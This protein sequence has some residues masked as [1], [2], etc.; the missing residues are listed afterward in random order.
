[1]NKQKIF[2]LDT[3]VLLHDHLCIYNFQDNDVVIPIVVLEELDQFKK[4]NDLINFQARQF[5]REL[6]KLAADSMF[7]DGLPLGDGHGKL[8]VATGKPYP[9]E[10]MESFTEK[11]PDHRILA[12][13]LFIGKKFSKRQTVLITK[14]VNLR[15]KA[16][17]LGLQAEDYETDKVKDIG[18]L[19]HGVTV[20]DNFDE[21]L[22]RALYEKNAVPRHDF[23]LS[24]GEL[25]ANQY[26]V[27]KSGSQSVLA[28]V[29]SVN[30]VVARVE[31]HH[32]FGIEP[33]NAEQTFALHA[34]LNP[35]IK[36]VS[37]TGKAGTGKTLLALAA[38]LSLNKQYNEILL[39]RPIVPLSN[40]DIGFLPGD[41]KDKIGPYMLPL[42]DNLSVIKGKFGPQSKENLIID[43]MQRTERLV[44]SPLAYIRGRSLSDVFFIVDEAQNLTPHEV[45]TIITR[46]GEGTK[47]VFTGD[48]HQIDTPYLDMQSNGL[49][50][51]TDRMKGQDIFAHV[52]LVKGERSYLAELA[53]D[54][55]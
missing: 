51:L 33:R 1:M 13:A 30:Q 39:A 25:F 55:L 31:K 8:F 16:K 18:I 28:H 19:E 9:E 44:I 14:D 20:Y 32:A 22:I 10:M 54:L 24:D 37:L 26:F 4:G 50:Y 5:A 46:A 43:E 38:A 2:V 29:D 52:N 35:D 11:T 7:K 45:K 21:S 3:N 41:V 17:S 49:A 42:F 40:R 23:P 36:L 12:I 27:L 53:S 47:M 34:L 48:V 6:D 15:M